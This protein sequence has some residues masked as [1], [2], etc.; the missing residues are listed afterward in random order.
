MR[1]KLAPRVIRCPFD[2]RSTTPCD[3]FRGNSR[4]CDTV[5]LGGLILRASAADG[6]ENWPLTEIF[7]RMRLTLH[8]ALVPGLLV[9]AQVDKVFWR[10]LCESFSWSKMC[11][12]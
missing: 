3:Y 5:A 10:I 8:P 7:R 4:I 6:G 2:K 9:V 11:A 12:C 1:T